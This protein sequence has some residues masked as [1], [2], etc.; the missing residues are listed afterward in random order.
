MGTGMPVLVAHPYCSHTEDKHR[1]DRHGTALRFL[2]KRGL[3]YKVSDAS[4]YSCSSSLVVIA[5][6]DVLE[7]LRLPWEGPE[8][9]KFQAVPPR[10]DRQKITALRLA[11]DKVV[12]DEGLQKIQ[13]KRDQGDWLHVLRFHCDTAVVDRSGGFHD[14]AREQLDEAK[15]VLREHP[16]LS[17]DYLRFWSAED[18]DYV[19]GPGSQ[20]PKHPKALNTPRGL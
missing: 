13:R 7:D 15:R 3:W 14:L 10:P 20:V 12:R 5:R 11:G 8:D 4:W 19:L 18:R 6:V 17:R 2:E 1:G 16:D 9:T